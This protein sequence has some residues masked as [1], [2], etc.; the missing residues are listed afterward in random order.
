M[1]V[2]IRWAATVTL[3]AMTSLAGYAQRVTEVVSRSQPLGSGHDKAIPEAEPGLPAHTV[4]RPAN[5]QA[6]G[7][8]KLPIVLWGEGGCINDGTRFRWFLSEIA[9]QGY[10]VLALGV[11]GDPKAEIW[12]AVPDNPG[13]GVM[14]PINSIPPAATR[15]S[16]FIEAL[17]WAIAENG[18]RDSKYF[19]KLAAT[20]VA[21]MG[22]SCG[23]LQAIEA[24]FDPRVT[25]TVI[26]NSG[27]FPDEAN[28]NRLAGGRDLKKADLKKL[29]APV[30][31]I[32]GDEA[33]IAFRNGNDDF[34]RLP[35]I[36]AL[37]AYRKKT[38]HDGTFGE[39]NGGDF[40][41]V[42]V[43]WLNWQLKGDGTAAKMFVGPNC[44]LC[45]DPRWVVKQ[46]NLK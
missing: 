26:W 13:P 45:T 37:R 16:Q 36:P 7:S 42:G 11:M 15:P 6:F 32:S 40:G 20:E 31:Y 38:V 21:A 19:G 46:K 44:A 27:M 41:R 23:G 9:S 25:T 30:A 8:Q 35:A 34:E 14:P 1:R 17:D 3:V 43:A 39:R 22:M 12:D 29:H 24:S 2:A 18:R 33:D 10:L 28:M 5:L 4:Y